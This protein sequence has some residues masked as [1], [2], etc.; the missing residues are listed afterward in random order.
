MHPVPVI[1]SAFRSPSRLAAAVLAV[2]ILSAWPLLAQGPTAT[3]TFPANGAV[4]AD[5]TQPMQW[6]SVS[7]AQ[8]YY[9]YVG[10]SAGAK[11]VV[12][13]GE[14]A[15]T[16]YLAANLPAG[17]TLYVRLWTKAGGIWRSVDST[18]S[19]AA[20]APV[21]AA[22]TFPANGAV[23]ADLTQ[24]MQWTSIANVQAYYL[25]VGTTAGAKDLVNSG[26]THQTSYLAVNL[27]AGQ[28]LYARMWTKVGGVW[29]FVDSTFTAAPGA[30]VVTHPANGAVNANLSL[31]IQWTSVA[32]VQAYYLY[33]G[34]TAGAKNVVNTGETLQ[35]SYLAA[36]VPVGQTLYIRMWTKVGGVWRYLDSTF[37]AAAAAPV[38]AAITFPANGA[39]NADLSQPIQWTSVANAQ[40]YYLYLGTSAGGNTLV[41]S[42]ETLQT[43]YLAA[44][45]P[46][47]Q[48]LYARLWTKVGGVW[49][50]VDSTFSAATSATLTAELTYPAD[51]AANI[52]QM[53]AAAWTTVANAQ[54]YYLYVGTTQGALDLIDSEETQLTSHAIAGLP[55]GPTLHA[56]LWTKVGGVWRYRDSTFTAGPY[57]PA[58]TSPTDGATSVDVTQ[59]FQW[60]P[61]LNASL[62][63]LLVGSAPGSGDLFDSGEIAATSALAPG[64]PTA[65]VLYARVMSKVNAAWH[66]T[67]IA[68]TPAASAALATLLVPEDGEIDFDTAR[69][70]EWEAAPLADAYRLRIGTTAGAGDLHDSGAIRVTQRFVPGLPLGLLFGRLDTQIGGQW[71]STDF[72]FTVGANTV[73]TT[74]QIKSATWA[75]DFVRGMGALDNRVLAG[76]PLADGSAPGFHA[77]CTVYAETL[78][79]VLGELNLQVPARR[80]DVSL[81]PN[82]YDAHTLVEMYIAATDSWMLLDPTF[83]L[84]VRRTADNGW[85]TAADVSAATRTQQWGDL[86]YVFLGPDGDLYAQDYYLDYPLLFLN[87]YGPGEDPVP[88]QGEPVLPYF[89]EVALPISGS[90]T[91]YAVGCTGEQTAVLAIDGVE[92][93]VDCSGVDGLSPVFG[94]STIAPTGGTSGSVKVYQPRRFQF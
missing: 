48:T 40:A 76:T 55:V 49:R 26:E 82:T 84:S 6:T 42:G 16:S 7:G 87:V 53:Q 5:L 20:A 66:H 56:R 28:T 51:Q 50:F 68:F 78:L 34:T 1:Q 25:Y 30:A 93:T 61:P 29:R 52:D 72:T 63:R 3:L 71:L 69:P 58:F 9:L 92:Q 10:T 37:T 86:T 39:V 19:A 2:T 18:F 11:D 24:P 85:A 14:L 27:P 38:T 73:S 33:V 22:I 8:A 12:N 90:H 32:N 74:L 41:N 13:S 43:S 91:V 94:A 21:T 75:T 45:L 88:G 83:D 4:N 31:P 79:D 17:Q 44:N 67:D 77:D 81:N 57:I 15:Q 89:L 36:N 54:A 70:F 65:G 59:P 23:N 62:H 80:L 64:L 47:G 46:A 60:T 35:T